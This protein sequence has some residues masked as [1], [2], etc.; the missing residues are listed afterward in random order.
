MKVKLYEVLSRCV[1]D[2]IQNA[3]KEASIERGCMD[4]VAELSQCDIEEIHIGVMREISEYI[5]FKDN[6]K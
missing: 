2:G 6:A 5:D 1:L 3:R 4:P